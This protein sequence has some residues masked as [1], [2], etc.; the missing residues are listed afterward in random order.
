MIYPDLCLA[1]FRRAELYDFGLG[2]IGGGV[3]DASSGGRGGN[4]RLT[5]FPST[6]DWSD[7]FLPFP[8]VTFPVLSVFPAGTGNIHS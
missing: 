4:F 2:G 6:A 1:E 3:A 5:F 8:G 7:F